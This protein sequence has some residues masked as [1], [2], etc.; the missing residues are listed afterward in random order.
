MR[1][2]AADLERVTRL[3][4]GT[5]RIVVPTREVLAEGD[6]VMV[7]VALGPLDDEVAFDGRV[8][9]IGADE[10]AGR[11]LVHIEVR[12]IDA[13]RLAYLL[14]VLEGR[15]RPVP[16]R[17]RRIPVDL[18]V[19]WLHGVRPSHGVLRSLSPGG[20]FVETSEP[21]AVGTPLELELRDDAGRGPMLL[22]GTVVWAG[23]LGDR[24]GFG[25]RIDR[26]SATDAARLANLLRTWERNVGPDLVTLGRLRP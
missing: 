10:R 12:P 22:V 8:A 15:R 7:E 17:H 18:P 14:D 25:F 19:R 26:R 16:R 20:A 24:L 5:Y 3:V 9:E 21:V 2:R 1:L 11:R 4:S 6:H 23:R 13:P